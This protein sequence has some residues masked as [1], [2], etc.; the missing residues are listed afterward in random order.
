MS[1]GTDAA[2]P[3]PATV[4]RPR[5]IRPHLLGVSLV[6]AACLLI[7]PWIFHDYFYGQLKSD[8]MQHVYIARAQLREGRPTAPHH[9]YHS[10]LIGVS[11]AA[12][13]T[14][15]RPIHA[16]SVCIAIA[17]LSCLT[18]Y[19]F[20]AWAA[21]APARYRIAMLLAALAV[22]SAFLWEL[23]ALSFFVE[24]P[25][26]WPLGYIRF[27]SFHSPTLNLLRPLALL[28]FTATLTVFARRLSRVQWATAAVSMAVLVVVSTMAKPNYVMALLPAVGL[29]AGL[30]VA[31]L[32]RGHVRWGL[33]MVLVIATAW[34]LEHQRNFVYKDEHQLR[35]DV[36]M[37]GAY[38][39]WGLVDGWLPVRY[40]L[41][42]LFPVAV[43]LSFFRSA[44]RAVPS[45]LALLS[46]V[47]AVLQATLLVE[48]GDRSDHGN[49][50]WG[51][52]I[53]LFVLFVVALAFFL[54]ENRVW[55][56]PMR[57][58]VRQWRFVVPCTILVLHFANGLYHLTTSLRLGYGRETL[59]YE[60]SGAEAEDQD[61]LIPPRSPAPA[62]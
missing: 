56:T 6:V 38:T 31:R 52:H 3:G 22:G 49:F 14:R 60:E 15:V 57:Q 47:I 59:L 41:S 20:L 36:R 55:D 44:T 2:A 61:D 40:L 37:F 34:I 1:P 5:R 53:T 23:N 30:R 26:M 48:A 13:D 18:T 45:S 4:T 32:G 54:R 58:L 11:K 7:F 39:E 50:T 28:L 42:A 24:P 51:Q 27:N 12:G 43:Y 21:G 8:Q 19:G 16:W 46:F 25:G 17:T 10:L 29:V 9:L 62:R 33:F 35:V